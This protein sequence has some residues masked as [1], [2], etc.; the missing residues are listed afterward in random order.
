[1]QVESVPEPERLA[2]DAI[3]LPAIGVPDPVVVSDGEDLL[4]HLVLG[5]RPVASEL[6]AVLNGVR[7]AACPLTDRRRSF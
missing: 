2:V 5:G 4:P 1:L 3:D 6:T 7:R